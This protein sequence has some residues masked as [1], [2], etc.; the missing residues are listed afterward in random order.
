MSN[1]SRDISISCS[2]GAHERAAAAVTGLAGIGAAAAVAMAIIQP[3]HAQ[4][5]QDQVDTILFPDVCGSGGPGCTSVGA[6][7]GVGG[8]VEVQQG[9]LPAVVEQRVRAAQCQ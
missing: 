2:S 4:S 9:G 7:G 5:F 8:Q 6:A 3:A 1:L